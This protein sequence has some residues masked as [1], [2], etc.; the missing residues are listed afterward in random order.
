M[1]FTRDDF[2]REVRMRFNN[3]SLAEMDEMRTKLLDTNNF[4][5]SMGAYTE[6][7]DYNDMHNYIHAM[8][9]AI[10]IEKQN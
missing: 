8:H 9:T 3:C 2:Q 4:L 7:K 5:Y 10:K 6:Y 1:T